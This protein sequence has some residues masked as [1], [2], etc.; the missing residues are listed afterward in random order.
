[1]AKLFG[2]LK[3]RGPECA[4]CGVKFE[5]GEFIWGSE[6]SRSEMC[7]LR[8]EICGGRDCVWSDISCMSLCKPF[9][10]YQVL[11][12]NWTAGYLGSLKKLV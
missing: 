9:F 12:R 6:I 5:V 11:F 10:W 2:G 1:M 7:Y 8:S 4:I 3:F